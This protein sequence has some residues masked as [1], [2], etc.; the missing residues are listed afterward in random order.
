MKEAV[1]EIKEFIT[2]QKDANKK[3]LNCHSVSKIEKEVCHPLIRLD[4]DND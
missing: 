3:E 2:E 1:E 4:I